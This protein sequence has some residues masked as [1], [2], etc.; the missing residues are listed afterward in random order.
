MLNR[1][2][3]D[4]V[5]L[6]TGS[7]DLRKSIDGLAVIVQEGFQLDPFTSSLFVFCNRKRDKLKILHW[8]HNGFWLYYRR[9]ENGVFQWPTDTENQSLTISQRQLNWLLD[10]LP[11]HHNDAHQK[12]S[13]KFV[14]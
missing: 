2:F 9:L 4:Q 8:E 14:I 5:Y 12:S 1:T 13:S 10:G 6:A 11:L 7:T 3:V